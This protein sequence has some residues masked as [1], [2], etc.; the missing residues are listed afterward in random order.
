M[1]FYTGTIAFQYFV[2]YTGTSLYEMWSL[3]ALNTLFTSLCTISPALWEQD[4]SATTLLAVPELYSFG[5]RDLG[6]STSKYLGWMIGGVFEGLVTFFGCLAGVG[7]YNV[8]GD[9]GLYAVGNLA[10]SVA[11]MWINWK[12]L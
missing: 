2:G 4:L 10:F 6:L 8:V 12:L 5:Q 3:T 9:K 1:Y 11:M 7:I